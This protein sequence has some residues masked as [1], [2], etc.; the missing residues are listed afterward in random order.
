MMQATSRECD[1]LVIGS[2]AGG[3]SAALTASVLGLE[4]IVCEQAARLGGAS[5]IS[6][7]EI[8][9][10]LNRQSGGGAKDSEAEALAYLEG[11]IGARLDRTRAQAYV[12]HAAEALAFIED[13]SE[14]EY[15]RLEH[16]VDYFSNV[17]GATNGIRTLGALP[18]DGRRLGSHFE[19]IR[20]PLAVGMI[21]GGLAVGREDLPHLLEMT[22]SPAST[23]HVARMLTRYAADRLTGYSRGTRMVMGNALVGRLVK[24]L[25]ERKVPMWLDTSV[26]ELV[27][28]GGRVVGAVVHRKD[29]VQQI[30]C[31]RAVVIASGSFSG[32]PALRARYFA[33]VKAGK[34]HHSHV[35]SSSDG[36]GFALA[37]TCGGVIDETVPQPGAWTPV[38]LLPMPDGTTSAFSHFGD[39]AKPGVIVV[40]RAGRRFTNEARNYHDFMQ[41]MFAECANDQAIEAFIVTSHRHLRK[42][43]LGRVPA[44]PGRTGPFLRSG[45]LQRGRTVAKLAAHIGVD[46]R[47][48]EAT[49]SRFNEHASRGEDP[50]FHKGGT[51]FEQVAGDPDQKPNPCVAPLDEGPW[52]AIRMIP[53]DI[54]T[55]LGL[56]VDPKARVLDAS[57]SAIPGLYAVGTVATS[58]MAGT[59]PAAGAMLGPSLTFGYLA[60]RDIAAVIAAA[61]DV[62][63]RRA[64]STTN[65]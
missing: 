32:N 19:Q 38:S 9:I 23:L 27:Q 53:G 2:G 47:T 1:V 8:W 25:L 40:N 12:R 11:V 56:L 64:S 20:P 65:A 24:T 44:F 52:Y 15:E 22:H 31:R 62:S 4:T 59:Y 58:I 16:V 33:H 57:G 41:A 14:V 63:P 35:P 61:S 48:L 21:F 42:Y 34:H 10:P 28:E 26:T 45:Y 36:S 43:G 29:G 7:G 17:A 49:I 3:L 13:N 37:A 60:A 6:G 18:Y 51:T 50:D 5:A 54:G 30:R 55:M 46:A 39:R